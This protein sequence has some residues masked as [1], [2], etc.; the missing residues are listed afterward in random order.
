[1]SS[2]EDAEDESRSP[3]TDEWR[4]VIRLLGPQQSVYFALL[5]GARIAVG[6]FDLALAAVMYLLFL[7]L[8]GRAPTHNF[9]WTPKTALET[10]LLAASL[11]AI[12]A[13]ADIFSS[14]AVLRQIQYLHK[15]FLLRL[16]QSYGE[17]QWRRF[18]KLNRSELSN[19]TIHTAR[20]AADFYHRCIE[21]VAGLVT[22]AVM[23][24]AFV[25]ESPIA[26][27]VFAGAVAAF[28]FG[29]QFLIRAKVRQA[30]SSR[31]ISMSKL[32]R[33]LADM[34]LSGKEIRAYGNQAFFYDRVDREA[35]RFAVAN[36]RAL[37]LP[38]VGRIIADQGT[39]LLFLSLIIVVQLRQG[40]SQNILA[41]LAFYFVLSRRMLPLVSQL[42]LI[43]GQMDSS[44][45]NVRIVE[46]ELAECRRYRALPLPVELP[47]PGMVLELE[48]VNFSF[49]DGANDWKAS[50]I[51]RNIN[52]GLRSGEIVVL[53]GASGI[54]K[55]SLLNLIA[56]VSQPVSGLV[57]SDRNG[58][59]Y[60][61]QE[62]A[63]LDESIR[64]NLL[65]GLP[66][67]SDEELMSALAVACLDDFVAAQP[68]GLETGAGD[69]GVLISGGERQRLGLARAILRG[70]R[71][72][73]L[74]EATSALDEDTERR[75]LE[76]LRRTG[77]AVFLATHRSLAHRFADR[78]YEL[79]DGCL[80]DA[81]H[82][83]FAMDP[84]A[85]RTDV[86][87]A[88]PCRQLRPGT[89]LPSS[90]RRA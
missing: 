65:F 38:H 56:G 6:F 73:L 69:N 26:A 16:T 11:V 55:S 90:T 76:N 54:G 79:Q 36:G 51:L 19:H 44:Y 8:E 63:L 74:D 48:Q 27:C 50:P 67:K 34:F 57:R 40:D 61:P 72:L 5:T 9:W 28:Y 18:V 35:E 41:L 14:R 71:L 60:V 58:I 33:K 83:Q 62:I 42:S 1:M 46:S 75:V 12:R 2:I 37:L 22:I 64:N 13:L 24:A 31:E 15:D 59:A 29:H 45:E 47:A 3:I 49:I 80:I 25:Y 53:H 52:F 32:Q 23:T 87:V 89:K 21:M 88:K 77:I 86:S 82:W 39:M 84:L 78:V 43:A 10:A 66:E 70:S 20:E 4:R 81:S 68:L 17:M 85:L 7:L 30:A